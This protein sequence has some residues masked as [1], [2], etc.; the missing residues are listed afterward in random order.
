[1]KKDL[2]ELVFII[3]KSGSMAGLETDT[4]G[5]F[6]SMIEK[7]KKIEGEVLVTTYFFDH[8]VKMIHDRV[9]LNNI[10]KKDIEKY[11]PGGTTALIDA[12]GNAVDH[13]SKVHKYIREEDIPENTIFVITTDGQENSSRKYSS[14]EVKQKIESK[15]E[16]GWKFIFLGANIDAVETGKE[17]GID[18]DNSVTY[19][20]DKEGIELN[21]EAISNYVRFER[22]KDVLEDDWKK[23]IEERGKK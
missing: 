9:E 19:L 13:I 18:E 20:N 10:D 11:Q 17:F 1:M 3:D 7:Q 15:K 22:M 21:Y 6:N 4:I 5:G 8:R 23:D 16:T 12:I 2:T 14:K